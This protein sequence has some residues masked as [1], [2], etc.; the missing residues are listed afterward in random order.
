MEEVYR[1]KA[2]EWE[3][4]NSHQILS[5]VGMYKLNGLIFS[6]KF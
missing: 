3:K 4:I 2:S 6:E 5:I 1:C